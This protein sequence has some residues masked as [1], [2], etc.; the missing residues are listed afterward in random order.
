M[1]WISNGRYRKKDVWSS[2]LNFN[3]H[4]TV[5]NKSIKSA[6]HIYTYVYVE[7]KL[8]ILC[9]I[10]KIIVIR[11]QSCRC[12]MFCRIAA[13]LWI[14]ICMFLGLPDQDPLV[15]VYWFGSAVHWYVLCDQAASWDYKEISGAITNFYDI[16]GLR[17]N[18]IELLVWFFEG[19]AELRFCE[20][21]TLIVDYRK[22][23]CENN[24][25]LGYGRTLF[26]LYACLS[27]PCKIFVWDIS[28]QKDFSLSQN[29]KNCT[30]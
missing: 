8:S 27:K 13:V 15:P 19:K 17:Y 10:S 2:L 26:F 24:Y 4:S 5:E 28:S 21:S 7:K 23:F 30:E 16:R 20:G 29:V 6:V 14:R 12:R 18:L 25:I 11:S 1:H 9:K 3:F 22:Y